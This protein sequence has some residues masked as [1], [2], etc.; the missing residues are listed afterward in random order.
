[1]IIEDQF[2][3]KCN[4]LDVF[5]NDDYTVLEKLTS[6]YRE[7]LLHIDTRL[8]QGH[9]YE[10]DCSEK[11]SVNTGR[12]SE[13]QQE[14]VTT[15]SDVDAAELQRKITDKKISNVIKSQEELRDELEKA[16]EK[17]ETVSLHMVDLQLELEDR[18]QKKVSQWDAIKRACNIY[19]VNLDIHISLEEEADRRCIKFSF[20][21]HDEA[22]KD[23]YF[24]ELS[25]S[26]TD[27]TVEQIEPRLKKE[28]F[29]KLTALKDSSEGTKVFDFEITTFLC[30]V[31]S[32]FLKHYVKM[33]KKS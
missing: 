17:R 16:K 28:H 11:K 32:I 18:K 13:L 23:K 20:F 12:M 29:E 10:K 24:V 26:N 9:L 19:K 31:R 3:F 33:K 1:M 15:K 4:I 5:Q 7:F 25:H 27:W 6:W 2:Q 14:I 21:T 30:E 8:E 22:M